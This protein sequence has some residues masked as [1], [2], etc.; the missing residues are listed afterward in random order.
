MAKPA[1]VPA[2]IREF[3]QRQE[4][5]PIAS[6]Y[7]EYETHRAS[8]YSRHWFRAVLAMLLSGRVSPKVDGGPNMTDVNR[9]CKEANFNQH[10]F[11]DVAEL[12]ARAEAVQVDQRSGTYTPGRSCDAFATH[13]LEGLRQATARALLELVARFTGIQVWRPTLPRD[14]HLAEFVALFGAAFQGLAL[15]EDHV[16]EV[17]QGLSELP[18]DALV[19]VAKQNQ[20]H[21]SPHHAG[22]WPHWLDDKGQTALRNA[23]Y[24]LFWAYC[25]EYKGKN[26][27]FLD[28]LAL[29]MLGLRDAVPTAPSSSDLKVL[30]NHSVFAGAGL[31]ISKLSALF[32]LCRV[33]RIDQVI[34]FQVNRR[35]LA[36]SPSATAPGA[37]L[38]AILQEVEPLPATVMDL[39]GTSSHLGGELAVSFC[40]A[41]VKPA[42]AEALDAIRRHPKLKGYLGPHAPPG[43]LVVK[44]GSDPDNFVRRCQQ[45]GLDVRPL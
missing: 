5:L 4:T 9:I 28:G 22:R 11:R 44:Y 25:A 36:E 34:E 24:A 7:P 18:A 3:V 10:L 31:P 39:L 29:G 13:D 26:W 23:L 27:F 17:W 33:K 15:R 1:A 32:R 40:S 6:V 14:S 41:L 42:T 20:L 16:G 38:G 19:Q 30:P 43:Y 2:P 21:I 8:V 37:E 45:L 35:R 12:L